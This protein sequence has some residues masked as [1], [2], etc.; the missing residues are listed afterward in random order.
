M[1]NHVYGSKS[2]GRNRSNKNAVLIIWFQWRIYFVSVIYCSSLCLYHSRCQPNRAKPS[3]QPPPPALHT[4]SRFYPVWVYTCVRPQFVC[5]CV[6]V[7]VCVCVVFLLLQGN[8]VCSTEA[9][10]LLRRPVKRS[11]VARRKQKHKRQERERERNRMREK[12]REWEI[13][14]LCG[15]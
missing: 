4:N 12:E 2:L 11:K 1:I 5:V 8:F 9:C 14:C 10:V 15:N 7:C 3:A 6:S 13:N